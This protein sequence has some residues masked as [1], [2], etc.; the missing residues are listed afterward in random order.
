MAHASP[1]ESLFGRTS[2]VLL[3]LFVIAGLFYVGG[4]TLAKEKETP[5]TPVEAPK[6]A[7]EE[8]T[9]IINEQVE[10]GW[11]DNKLTPSAKCSDYEFV[12]RVSLDIVG[13]IAT[14]EEVHEFI[15]DKG[16]QAERRAK[17]VDR[18]LASEDYAKNWANLWSNWTLT[19]TG[20]FGLSK[21][22]YQMQVWLEDQFA[23]N[24]PYNEIVRKLITAKGKNTVTDADNDG[25]AVNFILAHVGEP[26]SPGRRGQ[27][28]NN[29]A[30]EEGIYNMV[31]IT[32]RITRLFLGI[33]TQCTQCHDHPFDNKLK[34]KHFWGI[35]VFLRQVVRDG[36]PP[37]L[38]NFERRM[39]DVPQLTLKDEPENNRVEDFDKEGAVSYE[40]RNL[41]VEWTKGQFFSGPKLPPAEVLE[42]EHRTRRDVLADF[43]IEHENFP[44]A[45]VNR[46]WAHFFG[47]GIV[48]PI[49]DF[50]D[51]NAPS[52]PELL[53]EL[54]KK[55]KHYGYDQKKLIRWICNSDPYQLS[56]VSN[57]TNDKPDAEPFF[58]RYLLKPL[59]PE[60][61]YHSL[62]VATHMEEPKQAEERR[63]RRQDWMGKLISGFGDDEGNEVTF[64][65]TVVQALMMMNGDD[66]NKAIASTGNAVKWAMGKGSN[67]NTV[68]TNLYM[69]TLNRPPKPAE[70]QKITY[71]IK[72]VTKDSPEHACQDVLWALL[73]SNEFIL[74][75]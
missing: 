40:K 19:R 38:E 58:S 73:N 75:H 46:L 52:H 33:Q 12:R 47:R 74:N 4:P 53:D 45:Y 31:P 7:V 3:A 43:V 14:P 55:I 9:R 18:L 8:M 67:L 32:S 65:G 5:K 26:V 24:K 16:T 69:T 23:Q 72:G 59:S 70:M 56:A 20:V 6:A 28:N 61:L 1:R 62:I 30:H 54:A 36:V 10:A 17:L 29:K 15:N 60:Q 63:Q 21:Y 51:Q 25:G 11:K 42:K 2:A 68:V 66:I 27:V 49:D 57:K 22:H 50:N 37:T 13:R 34:Q 48:N 71:A 41:V 35:N 64:N 39:V 44:K